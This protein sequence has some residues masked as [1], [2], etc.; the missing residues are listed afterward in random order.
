MP[1]SRS[2]ADFYVQKHF[3][4]PRS[5]CWNKASV[6]NVPCS[7]LVYAGHDG[8]TS[9]QGAHKEKTDEVALGH[10]YHA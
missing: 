7:V 2:Q 9:F 10:T 3:H 4:S 5:Y 8:I 1:A 6:K